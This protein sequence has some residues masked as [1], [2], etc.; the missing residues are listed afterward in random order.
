MM[1]PFP[2]PTAGKKRIPDH[3][4]TKPA[5]IFFLRRYGYS[6]CDPTISVLTVVGWPVIEIINRYTHAHQVVIHIFFH[7]SGCIPHGIIG[8]E[9]AAGEG[10]VGF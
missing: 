2:I 1:T 5:I 7:L 9:Q 4:R 10:R 3:C 6:Q 8:P